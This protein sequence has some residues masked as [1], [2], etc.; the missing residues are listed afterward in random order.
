MFDKDLSGHF[1]FLSRE[2]M[3]CLEKQDGQILKL[4]N[5]IVLE[6][7][8]CEQA[9]ISDLFLINNDDNKRKS[10]KWKMETVLND[11]MSDI[12]KQKRRK[13]KS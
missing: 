1:L 6:A 9:T 4:Q 13:K 7:K 8:P 5:P 3:K 10:K 11:L 12:Q 2:C